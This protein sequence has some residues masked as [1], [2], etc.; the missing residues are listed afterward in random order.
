MQQLFASMWIFLEE[1]FHNQIYNM[2]IIEYAMK[3]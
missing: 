1:G 3:N 2:T